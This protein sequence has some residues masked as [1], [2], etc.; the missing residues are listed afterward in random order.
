MLSCHLAGIGLRAPGLSGWAESRAVLAGHETYRETAMPAVPEQSLL[1]RNTVRRT[2]Y[3]IRLTLQVA[4]EAMNAAAM[5]NAEL[6]SVF[7]CSGGDASALDQIFNALTLPD[8]PVSPNQFNNSVHNAPAGYWSIA[9]QSHHPSTS[10]SAYDGSFS[11]GL[12]EALGLLTTLRQAVLLIA[13][14]VPPPPPLWVHRPIA[15]P[16]AVA[17]LLTPKPAATH[18]GRLHLALA[19]GQA[20]S[21]LEEV[22]LE[23]LRGGNP[24]ARSLPLLQIIARGRENR[25]VLPY[26]TDTLLS[27]RHQPC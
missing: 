18:L 11:A 8:R 27:V 21:R 23:R 20:E 15:A 16:Y 14:D 13:Y 2:T 12:L 24:A 19:H 22:G 25:V 5:P 6:A 9:T 26:L 7:A 3:T 17:L 1:A 4:E 10:L